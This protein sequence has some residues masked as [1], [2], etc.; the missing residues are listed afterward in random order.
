[1]ADSLQGR[2]ALSTTVHLSVPR[3]LKARWVKDSQQRGLKLTDHLLTMIERGEAMK[4]YPIPEA[5][6]GQYHGAGYALAATAGGQLVA[7]RY[8]VDLAPE[9]DEPIAEGGQ[10]AR[11][12][13]Q[14]WIA[15]DAAGAVVRELQ[16]LG[17]VH[18]GM[19]SA[20]EF[21]EL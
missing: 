13:V 16:A 12:A 10:P 15:S 3:A 11:A 2:E 18:V 21:C 17:E 14:R 8:L 20:W 6:A 4:T 1:M 5:V 9:L 19:C 7:L